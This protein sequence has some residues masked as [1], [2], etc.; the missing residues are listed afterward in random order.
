[1]TGRKTGSRPIRAACPRAR[2]ELVKDI[3][4]VLLTVSAVLLAAQTPMFHRVRGWIAPAAKLSEPPA[5]PGRD[6]IIPY[7]LCV[8]NSLGLYGVSYDDSLVGQAFDRLSPLLAEG[9]STASA[10]E[11]VGRW[12]WQAFLESPGVYCHFQGTPP[13]SV[14]CAWLG[15]GEPQTVPEG[16]VRWILL[17]HSGEQVWLA[18]ID[19]DG[20]YYRAKTGL[21]YANQ[22][23]PA[24]E[25]YVPNGAA[26][27]YTLA[28]SDSAYAALAPFELV[29]MTSP[30][31]RLWTASAPDLVRDRDA[32]KTLLSA[33]GF[34]S[35]M[36][37]AYESGGK[38][39]LNERGDRLRADATGLVTFRAGPNNRYPLASGEETPTAAQAALTAWNLLNRV[40][41]PW[42]GE[43][44]YILTGVEKVSLGW[45]VTFQSRLGGVPVLSSE[46]GSCASF[47]VG[48]QGIT[49]FA[50][51][52]RSYTSGGLP[53]LL[54]AQRLAAAALGALPDSDG[55]L[56]LCYPDTAGGTLEAVWRTGLP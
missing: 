32:L 24:L 44:V 30:Q 56:T 6:G 53:S 1:M 26:F 17:A 49:G 13:I 50:L 14:L 48:D 29:S 45:T 3:L 12:Q 55:R 10:P 41:A 42:K 31:P 28:D 15:K 52:L 40:V 20:G 54:P 51:S 47:T 4:I 9:I 43:A 37:F 25:A 35:G 8:R 7:E 36:G 27:A 19:G 39:T 18:W 11:R 5:V 23:E 22:L 21:T 34:R 33:L 2:V 16:N 38:L 46:E